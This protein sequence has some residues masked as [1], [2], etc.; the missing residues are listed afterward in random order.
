LYPQIEAPQFRIDGSLQHGGYVSDGATLSMTVPASSS[1]IDVVLVPEG[2]PVRVHVPLDDALH[3]S[4]TQNTFVPD[5]TWTDGSTTTGVGYENGS[6]YQD[7]IG[8][9]VGAQMVNRATSAYC[10]VQFDYD[11]SG[12]FEKLLLC[13]RYD[14]GFIAYLN[15]WVLDPGQWLRRVLRRPA[16]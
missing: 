10:G 7:W 14:D 5:V 12:V 16:L 11:G 4:W 3:L 6:G 9:D 1:Y 8:T 13:M 15:G 2:V